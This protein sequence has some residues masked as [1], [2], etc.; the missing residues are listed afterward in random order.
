MAYW[1]VATLA[2]GLAVAAGWLYLLNATPV[3]LTWGPER[4]LTLPLGAVVLAA[5]AVGALVVGLVALAGALARRWRAVRARRQARRAARREAATARAQELVW[6]GEYAQ[7]R[8][9]LLRRPD[10]L[11]ADRTR[12]G[13]LAEAHLHESDPAA[14]RRVLE[15]AQARH[16]PDAHLLDLLA[17]AAQ[18]SGDLRG[19][20]EALERARRLRPGSP[21]LLRRLRE[22]RVASGDFTGA[23]VAQQELLLGLRAPAALAAE[24]RVM[25]GLR[26]EAACAESDERSA[27]KRLAAIAGETPDF[28]PAWVAAGD[29]WLAAGRPAVA[30]R[31]WLRGLRRYPQAVLLERLERHDDALGVPDRM[32]SVYRALRRHHPDDA[33]TALFHVRWLLRRDAL[34]EAARALETLPPG[35]QDTP[36]AAILA[37]ELA[38]RRGDTAAATTAWARALGPDLGFFAPLTCARC[39]HSTTQWAGTCTRCGEWNTLR[40]AVVQNSLETRSV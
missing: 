23:V 35:A 28:T 29:R 22:L 30:R 31:T 19:A 8:S 17:T 32:G 11:A 36:A 10:E 7:A 39:G 2:A 27:A 18:E 21:R 34:D 4:T 25:R 6:T 16:E 33:T 1:L 13:L 20:A 24:E 9:E 38:R 15:D 37:G 12:V 5:F 40:A 3:V 26:Y 14:A